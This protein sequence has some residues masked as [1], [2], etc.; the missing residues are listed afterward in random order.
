MPAT[1][2]YRN[3]EFANLLAKQF[4]IN[5]DHVLATMKYGDC[6]GWLGCPNNDMIF[7]QQPIPKTIEELSAIVGGFHKSLF[8]KPGQP[9]T[10]IMHGCSTSPLSMMHA[11]TFPILKSTDIVD[12]I[13]K[14]IY[15][16]IYDCSNTTRNIVIKEDMYSVH[17][18]PTLTKNL[19]FEYHLK[20]NFPK[21][22][23]MKKT[24]T[25]LPINK[26]QINKLMFN[27]STVDYTSLVSLR[28]Y[29][30]CWPDARISW[31]DLS[32]WAARNLTSAVVGANV[33][34]RWGGPVLKC[35]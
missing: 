16:C 8:G 15:Q 14:N 17:I 26:L 35:I 25:S 23:D 31:I 18:K 3:L 5:S 9:N 19:N 29:L 34:R 27:A 24:T 6:P 33:M 1:K 10:S 2:A 22:N 20:V 30:E 12:G 21:S 13:P 32:D 4:N 11:G 7:V 28:K